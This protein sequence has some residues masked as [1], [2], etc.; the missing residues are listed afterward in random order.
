MSH[1]PKDFAIIPSS[2]EYIIYPLTAIS[3]SSRDSAG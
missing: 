1:I 2:H 3:I